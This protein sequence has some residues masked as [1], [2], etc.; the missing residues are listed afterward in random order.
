MKQGKKVTVLGAGKSGIAAAN[1]LHQNG[2]QVFL[3]E[4]GKQHFEIDPVIKSEFCGHSEKIYDCDFAVISPGIP[5]NLPLVQKFT[6][7]VY[8][9]IEIASWFIDFPMIGI[10]GSNGKTTTT[11]I[12]AEMLKSSGF[13]AIACG[14]IGK[15]LSEIAQKTPHPNSVAVVELSSF[16]LET[17]DKFHPAVA[18]VLNLSP[19][20]LDRYDSFDDY[21]K[22]KIKIA[23]NLDVAEPFVVN[24]DDPVLL[25]HSENFTNRVFFSL[26]GN[27]EFRY[28]DGVFFLRGKPLI[29]TKNLQISGLHNYANIL[30]AMTIVHAFG[31][32]VKTC[33]NGLRNFGGIPHRLEK[34]SIP[35]EIQ[36][37]ND[38]KATNSDSVSWALRSFDQPIILLMGGIAKEKTY[39]HLQNLVNDKVKR[40][41]AFGQ[42]R[43][44]IATE[45]GYKIP[46][47]ITET[48][49]KAIELAVFHAENSDIILLSPGCASFDEFSNFE[50]RG[51][52][53][54]QKIREIFHA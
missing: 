25:K 37:Y 52:F 17:I 44:K 4:K 1:L 46:T 24:G 35:S 32:D 12:L 42:D 39:S 21:C 9:E 10:T 5:I 50:E 22:T 6:C 34:I 14:N 7:P 53:F 26:S 20:H 15:P 27:Q 38:S 18:A 3:S 31:A 43:E 28:E 45:F 41:I 48:L 29:E 30:A 40:I 51:D 8:S 47:Q 54:K 36:V 16:Q 19:D 49:H 33:L 13:H 11:A 23:K 2:M